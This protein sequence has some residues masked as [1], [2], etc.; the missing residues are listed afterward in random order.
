MSRLLLLTASSLSLFLLLGTC[1]AQDSPSVNIRISDSESF[2]A[3]DPIEFT[4]A[5]EMPAPQG[6]VDENW[7]PDNSAI[8]GGAQKIPQMAINKLSVKPLGTLTKDYKAKADCQFQQ[9]GLRVNQSLEIPCVL[10]PIGEGIDDKL[11]PS[12]AALFARSMIL[13]SQ[14]TYM[15]NDEPYERNYTS[16]I[17]ILPPLVTVFY[18]G[19]TGALLLALFRGLAPYRHGLSR[20]PPK[21]PKTWRELN[22]L[23]VSKV[24]IVARGLVATVAWLVLGGVSAIMLI[25]LTKTSLGEVSPIRVD[26]KDFTGGVLIGLLSFPVVS[27]LEKRLLA[28]E[29]TPPNSG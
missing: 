14:V 13:Q 28:S 24:L 20:A 25:I 26:V 18:G 5:I 11:L 6:K 12:R 21:I 8:D 23:I 16:R 29:M 4:V 19:M 9:Q 10:Y 7:K 22:K 3:L 2:R 27:W 1:N 15:Q 17:A